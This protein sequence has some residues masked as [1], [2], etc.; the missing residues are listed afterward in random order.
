MAR[1]FNEAGAI[2]PGKPVAAALSRGDRSRFNEAGA[3]NPGKRCM[4]REEDR[5]N[6]IMLQ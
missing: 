4:Q 6:A 3:I 5:K 1:S 2:N